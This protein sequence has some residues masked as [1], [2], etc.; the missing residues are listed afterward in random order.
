MRFLVF[1]FVV[2]LYAQNYVDVY[3]LQ[4]TKA[5][6]DE[7]EKKL[8]DEHYWLK[9]LADRNVSWGYYEN[10]KDIVVCVKEKKTLK[11]YKYNDNNY[12]L[13]D[14]I[15]VLTGLDGDKEKEGD[16]KTPVGVYRLVSIINNPDPFYGPFAFETS[17]PNLFDRINDKDGHGIWIH[18]VPL[19]GKR[20]DDNTRGCI[21]MKNS[22]L[23]ELKKEIDY[24][25][26]FLLISE[27]KPLTATKD[28]IAKILG[29]IYRWRKAWKENDFEVYKHFYDADFKRADGKGLK[30]FLDYKKRVFEGKKHQHVEILFRDINI[31][32]YQN[33]NN[34]KIFRINMFEKYN[35]KSYNYAGSKELYVKFTDSGLKIITEK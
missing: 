12:T 33:I 11:V 25:N 27:K 16:L 7:L 29:F 35:S 4:G 8:C 15:N 13:L 22:R 19:H 26:S 9:E 32:P 20:D 31:I 21:V 17:Y 34:Q 14:T 30:Q 1:F 10:I 6:V 18:G 5:L 2:I 24:L 3:R 28:E 23:E